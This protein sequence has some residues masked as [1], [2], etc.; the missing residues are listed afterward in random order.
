PV[1]KLLAGIVEPLLYD[2]LLV[3]GATCEPRLQLRHGGWKDEDRNDVA[4][5]LLAKLLRTLPVD[6]EEHVAAFGH[7]LF[8]RGARRSVEVAVHFGPFQELVIVTEI[9]E[10]APR[11]EMI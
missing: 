7:R 6:V 5:H 4:A 10:L 8:G 3:L 9:V 11:A 1:L 2:G